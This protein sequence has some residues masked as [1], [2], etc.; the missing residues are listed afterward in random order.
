MNQSLAANDS[1]SLYSKA[2]LKQIFKG[3]SLIRILQNVWCSR[4]SVNGRVLDLGGT[5]NSQYWSY[6]HVEDDVDVLHADLYQSGV[7]I[8]RMNFEEPFPFDDDCFDI[9][10]LMNVYEHIFDGDHLIHEISRVLKHNGRIVGVVPFLFPVHGVPFDYWR[11]TRQAI[12]K[13]FDKANL[14]LTTLCHTGSGK[15]TV[16]ASFVARDFRWK[17]LTL[18]VYCISDM[19]DRVFCA[20]SR[21]DYPLGYAFV[22][23]KRE[24]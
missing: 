5:P 23:T 16:G 13:C 1:V 14:D 9:V 3:R 24:A 18:A 17:P 6:L 21:G 4:V 2:A 12:E 11:P 20:S 7:G 15:W 10:L 8:V 22:A 19:I